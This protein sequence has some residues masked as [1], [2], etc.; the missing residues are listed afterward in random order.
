LALVYF[1]LFFLVFFT[2]LYFTQDFLSKRFAISYFLAF[3]AFFHLIVTVVSVV[4]TEV[5]FGAAGFLDDAA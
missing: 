5:I 4:F 1:F 2:V 3:L